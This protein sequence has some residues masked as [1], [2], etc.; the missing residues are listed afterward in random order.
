MDDLWPDDITADDIRSPEEILMEQA[1]QLAKTTNDLL[2]GHV[3][4]DEAQDRVILGLEVASRVKRVRIAEVEH[5]PDYGYPARV[6]GGFEMPDYLRDKVYRRPT[7]GIAGLIDT[8]GK[9]VDNK[10]VAATPIEFV[11][12]LR[13]LLNRKSVRATLVSMIREAK[14]SQPSL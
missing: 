7:L 14:E 11:Q 5:R 3:I 8:E 4:A 9:W 2:T 13:E 12:I 6:R 10:G 1:K